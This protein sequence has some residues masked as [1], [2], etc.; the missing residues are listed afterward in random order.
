MKIM[1]VTSCGLCFI[2]F[3]ATFNNISIISWQTILLVEKGGLPGENHRSVASLRQTFH[4]MLYHVHLTT[5]GVRTYNVSG[6]RH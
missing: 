4:I 6:A 2:K 5:N 1:L 3:N